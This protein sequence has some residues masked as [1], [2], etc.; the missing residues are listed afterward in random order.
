M[1]LMLLLGAA[2]L[3]HSLFGERL[4]P[5]GTVYDPFVARGLDALN[6]ACYQDA[7]F[8]L[9]GTPSGVTLAPEGGAH[10]SIGSPLIGMARTGSRLRAR[11][12]RRARRSSWTGPSTTCSATARATRT[13]APGCAT[14]PAARSTC[15][16][17]PGRWS[18]AAPR[19]GADFRQGVIDG[20]YW[21]REPGPNARW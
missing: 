2:G 12:P 17:R 10:Q 7:R 8:L 18:S 1:N 11:L 19:R 5:I 14:R 15:A 20:A 13:S 16:S 3:S 9:V 4:I 6:Y 21:L